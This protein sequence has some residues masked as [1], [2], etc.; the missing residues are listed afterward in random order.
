MGDRRR[1]TTWSIVGLAMSTLAMLAFAAAAR[2]EPIPFGLH[3]E[4][5]GGRE[6]LSGDIH[7]SRDGDYVLSTGGTA[8]TTILVDGQPANGALHLSA[9][10]HPILIERDHPDGTAPLALRWARD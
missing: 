2:F 9:G 7:P 10:G 8:P 6:R 3:S 5:S 1:I 4:I